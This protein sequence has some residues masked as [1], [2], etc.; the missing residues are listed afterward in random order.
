MADVTSDAE[1]TG[2][3]AIWLWLCRQC[4]SYVCCLGMAKSPMRDICCVR[5]SRP[6]SSTVTSAQMDSEVESGKTTVRSIVRLNENSR[7]KSAFCRNLT[8]A[9]CQSAD[10][11]EQV[12]ARNMQNTKT[13][14]LEKNL[15]ILL[16]MCIAT[17]PT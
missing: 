6:F 13:Q 7:N 17:S 15:L 3:S 5:P 10:S 2:T 9:I 1:E 16:T 11:L 14:A 4:S 8:S 12:R